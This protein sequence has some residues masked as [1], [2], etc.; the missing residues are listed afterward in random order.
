MN[1]DIN[2]DENLSKFFGLMKKFNKG[3]D[4]NPELKQRIETYFSFRWA[5]DKLQAIDDDEEKALLD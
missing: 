4:I 3:K 2:D 1:G 5:N